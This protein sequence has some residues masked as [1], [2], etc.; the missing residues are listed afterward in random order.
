MTGTHARGCAAIIRSPPLPAELLALLGSGRRA[1]TMA[2]RA[3]QTLSLDR[4]RYL[5]EATCAMVLLVDGDPEARA[6]AG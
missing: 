6:W 3:L 5:Y 2:E 4:V 1:V